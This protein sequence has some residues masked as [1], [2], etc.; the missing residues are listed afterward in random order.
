M[1]Y[2]WF[3]YVVGQCYYVQVCQCCSQIGIV[4][5]EIDCVVVLY[6]DVFIVVV[7][8]EYVCVVSVWIEEVDYVV[9]GFFECVWIGWQVEM[10]YIVG[11]CVEVDWQCV[12]WLCY[13]CW[14]GWGVILDYIVD[15]VGDDIDFVVIYVDVQ[16]DFWV[17]CLEFWQCWYQLQLCVWFGYIYVQVFVW[18][19]GCIVQFVFYFVQF[20]Q[21]LGDVWVIGCVVGG[22]VDLVCGVVEQVQLQ[23]CFQLLYQLSGCGVVDLQG[24]CCVGEVVG[25]YYLGKCLYCFEMV[26]GGL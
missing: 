7:C 13:Q 21:Q 25:F 22:D 15:V 5:V 17:V 24:L 2:V 3:G 18:L 11:V 20:G 23:V 8:N 6:F 10:L 9:V 1:C 14:V 16:L 19:G 26:Y 12:E 4:V